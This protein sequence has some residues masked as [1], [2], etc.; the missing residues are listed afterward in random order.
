MRRVITLLFQCW[1][2]NRYLISTLTSF[3]ASPFHGRPSL[4]TKWN[5]VITFVYLN[6]TFFNVLRVTSGHLQFSDTSTE[7]NMQ[8]IATELQLS[9]M[10]GNNKSNLKRTAENLSIW[11]LLQC[12]EEKKS[13]MYLNKVKKEH[14]CVKYLCINHWLNVPYLKI[15]GKDTKRATHCWIYSTTEESMLSAK[16]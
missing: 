12:C 9:C 1:L 15:S 4:C 6:S 11:A 3:P 13:Q 16:A 8:I 10:W 5:L 7:N 2:L 14:W